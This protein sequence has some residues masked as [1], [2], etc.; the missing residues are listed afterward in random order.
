MNVL[1]LKTLTCALLTSILLFN[2]NVV[3]ADNT[4][5]KDTVIV[6]QVIHLNKSTV[7]D[8][9]TLKGIGH[10]KAQAIVAYRDQV[11][12][13]KSV[14]DLIKVKGIGEK[15]LADNIGRLKI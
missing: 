5:S 14:N 7:D 10:K 6:E 3:F 12:G 9:V 4:V 11:G 8:L 1:S 13:F 15:V 2:S